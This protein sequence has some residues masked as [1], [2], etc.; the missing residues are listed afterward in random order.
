MVVGD[1]SVTAALVEFPAM[2]RHLEKLV[3]ITWSYRGA[4]DEDE[5]DVLGTSTVG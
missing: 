5:G 2:Q 3:G 4:R 1:Q